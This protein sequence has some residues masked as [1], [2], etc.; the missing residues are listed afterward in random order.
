MLRLVAKSR[1]LRQHYM[2][3]KNVG[4]LV[5][6]QGIFGGDLHLRIS[7]LVQMGALR[8]P[9]SAPMKLYQGLHDAPSH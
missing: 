8:L 5:Y 4:K 1:S 7:A 6:P 9:A 2:K 3:P